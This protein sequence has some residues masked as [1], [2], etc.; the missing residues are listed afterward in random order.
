MRIYPSFDSSFL[1][2]SLSRHIGSSSSK[3]GPPS[4]ALGRPDDFTYRDK[5]FIL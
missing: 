4:M 1:Q 3:N 5:N 2:D